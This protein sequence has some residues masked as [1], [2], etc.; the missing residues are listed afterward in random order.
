VWSNRFT[1]TSHRNAL[2]WYQARGL[3]FPDP[4]PE[5]ERTARESLARLELP[6]PES[7]ASCEKTPAAGTVA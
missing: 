2:A 5:R 3:P 7:N 1:L 6:M 4:D